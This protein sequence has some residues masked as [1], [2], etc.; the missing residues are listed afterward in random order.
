MVW[1]T[2]EVS[3]EN[4]FLFPWD[5]EGVRNFGKRHTVHICPLAHVV[6]GVSDALELPLPDLLVPGHVVLHH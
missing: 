4:S 2:I 3:T 5:F 6:A 1:R